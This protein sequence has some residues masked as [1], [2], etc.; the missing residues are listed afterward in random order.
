[1]LPGFAAARQQA[2]LDWRHRFNKAPVLPGFA[3]GD[4]SSADKPAAASFN[5]AP[6]LPGFAADQKMEHDFREHG[7]SIRPRCYRGLRPVLLLLLQQARHRFNKAPVLPGFAAEPS[8]V[9]GFIWTMVSIR[10]RCYR[11]LRLS[12][13]GPMQIIGTRFQ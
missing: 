1:M 11:G 12:R 7:V 3:A 6:V 4:K 8:D 13:A 10:P 5:K 9:E 2:T